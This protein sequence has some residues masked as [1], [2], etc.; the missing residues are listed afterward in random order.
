VN[1]ASIDNSSDKT[2]Q[3]PVRSG[4][5]RQRP[6]TARYANG[7]ATAA[8]IMQV[9]H[10]LVIE[11]GMGALSIRQI[12]RELQMSPGNLSYYY[13]SKQDL[14]ADLLTHVLDKFMAAFER[15]REIQADSPEAQLRAV[16]EY[17]YDDLGLIE[18][19]NFFPELWVLA[20]RDSWAADQ[21]ERIYGFCRSV[22]IDILRDLRPDLDEQTIADIALTISA[23]IEGHTVFLGH[24][25]KHQSR[26]PAVK[27]L[28]IEQLVNLASTAPSAGASTNLVRG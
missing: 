27:K 18:T 11:H 19:T 14:L 1:H 5:Q 6:G 4:G 24:G 16:M 7:Q 20:L 8:R 10:R 17:V 22:L 9:A 21:M 23:T 3:R 2:P 28:I 15:L 26:A 12:A 13:A 25:R